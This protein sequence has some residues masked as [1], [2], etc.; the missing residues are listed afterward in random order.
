MSLLKTKTAKL[1]SD[2]T[3]RNRD[4]TINKERAAATVALV[5]SLQRKSAEERDGYVTE[6]KDA[7]QRQEDCD[8]E[9]EKIDELKKKERKILIYNTIL[10]ISEWY[11]TD[12]Q[13]TAQYKTVSCTTEELIENA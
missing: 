3:D 10:G 13:Y 1:K 7:R 6:I 2:L 4:L 8:T 11:Q 5:Q 12:G 9:I